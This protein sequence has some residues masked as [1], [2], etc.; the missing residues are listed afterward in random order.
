M[1]AYH[2]LSILPSILAV[3]GFIA[4]TLL[5]G[6]ILDDHI[7]RDI[8]SKLR[9]QGAIDPKTYEGMTPAKL[10]A[11]LDA[12]KSLRAGVNERDFLLLRQTLSQQ[13]AIRVIVYAVL[14]AIFFFGVGAYVYQTT[15]PKKL[16]VSGIRVASTTPAAKGLAVD[17]DPLEVTWTTDGPAEDVRVSL[18]NVRS[19]KKTAP[20]RVSSSEGRVVFP[21]GSYQ[22]LLQ[23]RGLGEKNSLRALVQG[24]EETFYS[25]EVEVFVGVTIMVAVWPDKLTIASL[26]DNRLTPHHDFEAELLLPRL[27]LDAKSASF[28]AKVVGGKGDFKVDQP[29]TINWPMAKLIY[30]GSYDLRIVR[31]NFLVDDAL[32]VDGDGKK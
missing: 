19:G 8:V 17:T 31:Q 25:Q 20:L 15:R 14:A 11:T 23:E 26:V 2:F 21:V 32:K 28:K 29:A 16:A 7:V 6:K 9:T 27:S 13:F 18:E 3:L 24:S 10:K 30:M 4:F 1:S 5:R 22:E 12:D